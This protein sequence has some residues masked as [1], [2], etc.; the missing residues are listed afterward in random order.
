MKSDAVKKGTPRAPHRSL[1]KALGF[2]DE[3]LERPLVGIAYSESEIVPGHIHLGNVAKAAADGVRMAGGVP[4]RFPV[5]GVCDGIAMG[6][7]GMRYSLVT[8]ELIADS[9]ECMA[10]AHQFDALVFIPNCD[11]IVPGMLMAAARLNL[12]SIFVSGGPMLAGRKDGKA[13]TLTTMFEAVGAV[14]SGKMSEEELHELENIACPGCGSCSG[15]FTANSM[16]CVTEALGLALSGNG[17]C[18]AVMA[19]RIR[20]AKKT[21]LQVMEVLKK[22]I[23][24]RAIL[25]EKAFMNALTVD[26]ALG[27]ST[28]TALHLPAIAREAGFRLDFEL[29]NKVSAATPNLCRLSPA[30]S[31][32]IEDLHA[33]GGI[34]AVLYELSKKNLLNLD[35]L[36]VYGVL[37]DAVRGAKNKNTDII[38]PIDNPYMETGG[39]AALW[40]NLAPDG[41]VVKQ[42]AVAP[43]MLKHEGPAR[44]FDGEDEAFNA[45]TSGKINAGDVVVIRYEGPRGGPGMKEML[46]PTSALAGMGLD[47]KVALITDGRFSGASRGAAIGHLSPE[48]ACGGV[49]ALL[50]E[51]DRIAID[52]PARSI[53]ALVSDEKLARRRREWSAPPPKVTHGCLARYARM[54]GSAAGG[55]VLSE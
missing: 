41:C 45:I 19:E 42:S 14:A 39:L 29:L 10:A 51:G 4:V 26:M 47:D 13:L 32:V 15:M 17:T 8:R 35:A 52:I 6:H 38:R 53:K 50:R 22:D 31:S 44:V 48:A 23:R 20:L 9:V 54:V 27:C 11:K 5:I 24:P 28:N 25:T 46:G 43:S 55:A 37:G 3:E 1:F 36:T 16:N 12:P 2:I 40:G 34:P 33:A 21:G 49:I 30:G 18:P 7:E